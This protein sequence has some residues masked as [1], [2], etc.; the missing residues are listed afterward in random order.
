MPPRPAAS[1]V[2]VAAA[3][4][5][6]P[7]RAANT[8]SAVLLEVGSTTRLVVD[9][10]PVG[11]AQPPRC[12]RRLGVAPAWRPSSGL[13]WSGLAHR[14]VRASRG[15][16]RRSGGCGCPLSG[17]GVVEA[18]KARASKP[19]GG[20]GGR[21]GARTG[22]SLLAGG[23]ARAPRAGPRRP[24][25]RRGRARER[26]RGGRGGGNRRR[27]PAAVAGGAVRNVDAAFARGT[28]PCAVTAAR[29]SPP[30]ATAAPGGGWRCSRRPAGRPRVRDHTRHADPMG[31]GRR[32][33]RAAPPTTGRR[34]PSSAGRPPVCRPPRRRARP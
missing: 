11:T 17:K 19:N 20:G 22:S 23:P 9:P 7:A 16:A 2:L 31:V 21:A 33:L 15:R 30:A 28:A 3:A 18:G 25:R 4:A 5:G 1:G 14:V 27:V 34:P 8:H 13:R 12:H 10:A 32:W 29:R 26:G 6:Q 24:P